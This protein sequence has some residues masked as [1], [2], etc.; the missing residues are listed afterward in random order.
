MSDRSDVY[1]RV[2]SWAANLRG[3][4]YANLSEVIAESG[5][6]LLGY[7]AEIP[8]RTHKTVYAAAKRAIQD[9]GWQNR[10]IC[11]GRT[12]DGTR[13]IRHRWFPPTMVTI[14]GMLPGVKPEILSV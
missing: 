9:L 6:C 10:S 2:H 12:S 7:D 5:G 1:K 11:T 8:A 3:G 14:G 4:S 13:I